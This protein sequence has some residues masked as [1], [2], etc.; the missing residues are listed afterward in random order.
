M[1]RRIKRKIMEKREIVDVTKKKSAAGFLVAT[2]MMV[3]YFIAQTFI[4]G[5][6]EN[7]GFAFTAIRVGLSFCGIFAMAMLYGTN[8]SF[9]G[10][11][12]IKGIFTASGLVYLAS[13]V[14]NFIE[15]WQTPEIGFL[16]AFPG[17]IVILIWGIGV[18]LFEEAL[19]RGV[20]FNTFRNRMGESRSSIVK[21]IIFSSLI[22]G[23]LHFMNLIASPNLVVTICTQVTYATLGGISLAC[24]Y[25]ITGNI[26]VVSIL[27]ALMD[28]A[29]T[30]MGCFVVSGTQI[31]S[32]QDMSI[33]EG[34]QMV[35][36]EA[37]PTVILLILLFREFKKRGIKE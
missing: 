1:K 34:I 36:V 30:I 8:F 28:I 16:Q 11:D 9:K 3:L 31:F 15:S 12:V 18:G 21:A 29:A 26:W 7:F 33:L 2:I 10:K 25:Y 24:I 5:G 23:C 6:A 14:H 4:F 19:C 37:I 20:L 35:G 13:C 27:H 32:E 17:V 22:F